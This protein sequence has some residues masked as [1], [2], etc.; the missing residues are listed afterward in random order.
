LASIDRLSAIDVSARETLLE[1]GFLYSV[2]D[3]FVLEKAFLEASREQ[4]L[5]R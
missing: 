5:T 1:S 2:V 4:A 3:G